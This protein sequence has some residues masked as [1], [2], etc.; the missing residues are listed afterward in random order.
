MEA[1][2]LFTDGGI[3]IRI[4]PAPSEREFFQKTFLLSNLDLRNVLIET[5]PHS[6]RDTSAAQKKIRR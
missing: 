6:S 5:T 4:T 1:T 3:S 2:A